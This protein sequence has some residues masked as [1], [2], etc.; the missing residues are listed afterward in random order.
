LA[1]HADWS[2][3]TKNRYLALIKLTIRLGERDHEIKA[4]SARPV[5]MR[6]EDNERVR[7]LN[8]YE[9]LPTKLRYLRGCKDEEAL[10]LAV[11]RTKY[12]FHE[13]EWHVALH[14]GLRRSEQYGTERPGVNLER[15][16]LTVP[17]SKHGNARH[18][19][20]NTVALARSKRYVLIRQSVR[21]SLLDQH[22]HETLRGNRQW[23]EDAVS[24]AGVRD[25]TW[26][27]L[28]HT[29]ASRLIMNGVGIRNVQKLMGHRTIGMTARYTHLEPGQ[30]LG[31]VETLVES[32]S[33]ACK[34]P[35]ASRGLSK[36]KPLKKAA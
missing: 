35:V 12:L 22:G 32:K 3:A 21:S 25:F 5:K 24:E 10:L 34:R 29:F 26:H 15:R 30:Q 27:D 20:L 6:K 9:P 2:T 8:Q 18:N 13:S 14:T 19:P 23:F 31:A 7:Y 36:R 16:V 11:I 17:R 33:H 1:L 28:R 4:N